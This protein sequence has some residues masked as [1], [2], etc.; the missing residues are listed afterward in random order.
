MRT[1]YYILFSI[2]VIYTLVTFVLGGILDG[3]DIGGEGGFEGFL[4]GLKPAVIVSFITVF[5]GIGILTIN[6]YPWY[7]S[8]G[9]SAA[10]GVTVALL[11]NRLVIKPLYGAQNTSIPEREELIGIK[12]KVVDAIEENGFGSITYRCNG[13]IY[14]STAKSLKGQPI[15]QGKIVYIIKIEKRI[16]YVN[17]KNPLILEDFIKN[18]EK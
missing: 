5:G 7:I 9:I 3:L 17:E 6:N 16:F 13:N 18:Y 8:A 10:S 15:E 4:G 14:K 1:L 12:A 11:I 2:G